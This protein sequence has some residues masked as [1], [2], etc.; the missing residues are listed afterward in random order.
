MKPIKTLCGQ[1]AELITV[2]EGETY[3]YHWILK[4]LILYLY[5]R[6]TATFSSFHY[7]YLVYN[8]K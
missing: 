8:I 5:Y 3:C 2:K 4:E 1:N 7:D 6:L